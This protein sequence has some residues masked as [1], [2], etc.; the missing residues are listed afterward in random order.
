MDIDYVK[1][2]IEPIF[3]STVVLSSYEYGLINEVY[4]EKKID[5]DIYSFA[6]ETYNGEISFSLNQDLF[7][8]KENGKFEL[9]NLQIKNVSGMEIDSEDWI[10]KILNNSNFSNSF[11]YKRFNIEE[12]YSIDELDFWNF[13]EKDFKKCNDTKIMSK[14]MS[15]NFDFTL[16]IEDQNKKFVF[17]ITNINHKFDMLIQT[18][19]VQN[20]L[21]QDFKNVEILSFM[22][23]DNLKIQLVKNK[24]SKYFNLEIVKE[25]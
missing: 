24:I 12:P 17:N 9:R 22:L 21:Y 10:I 20:I 15:K 1:N 16:K 18:N 25:D 3:G 8:F 7:R 2:I 19:R 11:I 13:F 4:V 14:S 5:N 6:Y 23:S